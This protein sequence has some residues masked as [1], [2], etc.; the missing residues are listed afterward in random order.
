MQPERHANTTCQY[1]VMHVRGERTSWAHNRFNFNLFL[2][3]L[4][5]WFYEYG[6]QTSLV[7]SF[8]S[9]NREM[10][11]TWMTVCVCVCAVLWA[12]LKQEPK[13]WSSLSL[14]QDW[15]DETASLASNAL[16]LPSFILSPSLSFPNQSAVTQHAR[17]FFFLSCL[18]FSRFLSFYLIFLH[19]SLRLCA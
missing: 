3:L 10:K 2:N 12:S 4:F 17:F 8:A 7:L 6:S 13:L 16:S 14:S 18:L 5:Y 15:W 1:N 11:T 9:Q 19:V